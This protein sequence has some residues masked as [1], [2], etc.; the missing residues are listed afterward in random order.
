MA[1]K[2]YVTQGQL[3]EILNGSYLQDPKTDG[4]VGEPWTGEITTN[5]L[6][7]GQPVTTDE[8]AKDLPHNGWFMGRYSYRR[9]TTPAAGAFT[10]EEEKKTLNEVAAS[11]ENKV[12]RVSGPLADKLK[13]SLQSCNNENWRHRIEKLLNG[14]TENYL[15]NFLSDIRNGKVSQDLLQMVGGKD[16][17]DWMTRVIGNRQR[18]DA[19]DK[20]I[21][22]DMGLENVYQKPGGAKEVGNGQ[23]HTPKNGTITYFN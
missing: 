21:K 19:D 1:R 8:F 10:M 18:M 7:D 5:P 3:D 17:V 16:L 9:G 14:A 4:N 22:H 2:V 11:A 20:R 15:S 6:P 13:M 23:A 12:S